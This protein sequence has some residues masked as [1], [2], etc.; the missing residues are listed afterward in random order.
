LPVTISVTNSWLTWSKKDRTKAAVPASFRVGSWT[1][2]LGSGAA[3]VRKFPSLPTKM[4]PSK[5]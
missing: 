3:I 4:P 5:V 2:T 1:E